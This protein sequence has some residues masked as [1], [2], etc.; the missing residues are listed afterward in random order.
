MRPLAQGSE[1]VLVWSFPD[2][3]SN[4]THFVLGKNTHG[5][6]FNNNLDDPSY[7]DRRSIN[8]ENLNVINYL[9]NQ[10]VQNLK[11]RSFLKNLFNSIEH[12]LTTLFASSFLDLTI[13]FDHASDKLFLRS[14]T[15]ENL[16]ITK[17]VNYDGLSL[18]PGR[19]TF[20]TPRYSINV[21]DCNFGKGW[22][23]TVELPGFISK[24]ERENFNIDK[25]MYKSKYHV[26]PV[27]S[28]F[29]VRLHIKGKKGSI[30]QNVQ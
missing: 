13:Y 22:I 6:W 1:R 5:E 23:I 27:T 20:F 11:T 12:I 18:V 14:M 10:L 2:R 25:E 8:Q 28:G 30:L 4:I 17:I 16:E 26:K 24:Q 15:K 7:N 29:E 19:R 9:Q 3:I 21:V